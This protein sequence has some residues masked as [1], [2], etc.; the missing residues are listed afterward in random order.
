MGVRDLM[1]SFL[2]FVPLINRVANAMK[3]FG[4]YAGCFENPVESFSEIH[5]SGDFALLV[6]NGADCPR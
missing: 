4:F 5:R 6:G 1:F 3:T 2:S